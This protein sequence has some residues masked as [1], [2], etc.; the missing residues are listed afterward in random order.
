M[1]EFSSTGLLARPRSGEEVYRHIRRAIENGEL[2]PGQ[3]L[4]STRALREHLGVSFYAVL[5]G[6]DRL[7]KE[8][9]ITRRRGSGSYVRDR[10]LNGS[11]RPHTTTV[12]LLS[13]SAPSQAALFLTPLVGAVKAE[14]ESRGSRVQE[15]PFD[16]SG[17]SPSGRFDG[18]VVIWVCPSVPY[19]PRLPK[20]PPFVMVS[21]DCEPI[22]AAD[23][24]VDIV[25]A[26]SR[27]GGALAGRRLR[28]AGCRRVVFVGARGHVATGVDVHSRLRLEGLEASWGKRLR[29]DDIVMLPE[30]GPADGARFIGEL[31]QNGDLPDGIFAA[32]DDLAMGICHGALAHGIKLGTDV[33]LIGYDG[34]PPRFSGDPLLTTVA[35]PLELMGRTAARMALERA[36]DPAAPTRRMCLGCS[37][38]EGDTA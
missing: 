22:V 18:D 35:V 36:E 9:W 33:K 27:Q 31:L 16:S 20:R 6:L 19:A 11:T 32:S 25:T 38:R 37:L 28:E 3:A 24:G 12:N 23:R 7:E 15:S 5:K 14:I 17:E 21:Q 8:G 13:L 26:D 10:D 29:R 30:Y 1:E 34:Q 4:A 2:R